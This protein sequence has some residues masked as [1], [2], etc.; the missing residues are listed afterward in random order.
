M[1]TPSF[2]AAIAAHLAS[3]TNRDITAFRSHL[4]RSD[5]L[6]TVVQTG[7]VF[8]TPTELASDHERWFADPDWIWEGEV[9]HTVVGQDMG[10]A[11]IRYRY[12]PRADAEGFSTW[13]VYVLR[14]E[15]GQWRIVHDQ[16]TAMDYGAFARAVGI[17][18]G[19]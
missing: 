19:D 9:V 15:D 11:L 3:I 13:L 7:H 17:S 16:N 6:Y 18:V 10:M 2:D 12:R 14:L 1:S 8:T 5:T 4:T